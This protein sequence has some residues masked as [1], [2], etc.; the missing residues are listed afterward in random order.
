MV[1]TSNE[2]DWESRWMRESAESRNRINHMCVTIDFIWQIYGFVIRHNYTDWQREIFCYCL[3]KYVTTTT[4]TSLFFFLSFTINTMITWL[5][6]RQYLIR[7]R[8][9]TRVLVYDLWCAFQRTTGISFVRYGN[10]S[11][12]H[13]FN[14][15][16]SKGSDQF[17]I[18]VINHA[19]F[20]HLRF[21]VG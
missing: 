19:V 3:L 17:E 9:H 4:N 15:S 2:R 8:L 11:R 7:N 10:W 12:P 5:I 1:R 20:C 16:I 6:V 13:F 14:S 21:I 18:D